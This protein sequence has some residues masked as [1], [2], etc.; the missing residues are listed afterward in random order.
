MIL[1]NGN[2]LNNIECGYSQIK[3]TGTINFYDF[4]GSVLASSKFDVIIQYSEKE[5][6]LTITTEN[7]NN[8]ATYLSNYSTI[9]GAV[10]SVVERGAV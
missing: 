7:T 2:P 10:F 5:T 9:N 3:G 1:F 6:R 8:S 4:D